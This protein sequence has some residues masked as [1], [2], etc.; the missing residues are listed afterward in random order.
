MVANPVEVSMV[1]S[2][3]ISQ[4]IYFPCKYFFNT[5]TVI[6]MYIFDENKKAHLIDHLMLNIL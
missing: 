5:F 3:N 1:K 2:L 4:K 6:E